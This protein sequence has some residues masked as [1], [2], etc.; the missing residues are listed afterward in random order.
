MIA[1]LVSPL[2]TLNMEEEN[3]S[4]GVWVASKSWRYPWWSTS[5]K[6]ESYNSKELSSA[7]NMDEQEPD[8]LLVP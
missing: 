6:T 1:E 2:L 4:Q 5:K 7:S 3:H 8:R